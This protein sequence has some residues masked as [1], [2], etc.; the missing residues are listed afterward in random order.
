[1][2]SIAGGG[3]GE[4]G[5]NPQLLSHRYYTLPLNKRE[6]LTLLK[7]TSSKTIKWAN[8]HLQIATICLQRPPFYFEV[9]LLITIS[10]LLE[11]VRLYLKVIP[12]SGFH[13]NNNHCKN[14]ISGTIISNQIKLDFRYCNNNH[15]L[16]WISGTPARLT[17]LPFLPWNQE[18]IWFTSSA[19]GRQ[20]RSV[21]IKYLFEIF[22]RK[23]CSLNFV[24]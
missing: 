2:V 19:N 6:L 13:C 23:I 10:W 16:Y 1:M 12:L 22:D 9:N 18:L 4:R 24:R 21:N 14:W 5:F 15:C 17:L 8:D 20:D 3:G 11:L 7:I